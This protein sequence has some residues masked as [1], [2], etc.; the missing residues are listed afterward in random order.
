M[1][2]AKTFNFS[3]S[4]KDS[5][6]WDLPVSALEKWE[7]GIRAA[8][9]DSEN[10]I[11][12]FDIIGED[13]WYDGVTVKRIDAALRSI[14]DQEVTVYINSPGGDMF[15]GLAIYNRLLQHTKKVTVK[16]LGIAASA[17]SLIAMAGEDRL[18]SQSSFLMIHNCWCYLAGNRHQIRACADQ[19][20]EFD[21]AMS[22]LY[23]ET[24][25]QS[26]ETISQMMDEESYIRGSKAVSLGLAT[27][28]MNSS[29]ITKTEEPASAKAAHKLDSILA[30]TGMPRSERRKLV[31]DLKSG[32]PGAT[33]ADTPGAIGTI[34]PSADL[35]KSAEQSAVLSSSLLNILKKQ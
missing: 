20:E 11:T 22:E 34:K 29:E 10:T 2:K 13:Y 35:I 32:M 23:S 21:M 27:G 31:S 12:I 19:M 6:H 4:A 28:L 14:G 15:E 9:E 1:P 24:S 18:I 7:P 26:V 25:G 5:L 30:R 33:G 17:A 3:P 16:I 8:A